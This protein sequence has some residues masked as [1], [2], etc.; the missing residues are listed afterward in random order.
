MTEVPLP[1]GMVTFLLTDVEGSTRIWESDGGG[2][3]SAF[4]RHDALVA[5]HLAA[6]GGARPRDQGEGDSAFAVF[7]R[8][9]AAVACALELQRA[10]Y[11]EAWPPDASIRV[12]MALHT[13]EAELA[14]GNY[15]G[16]AVH[17]CA[18]L[19]GLAHGGQILMSEATAQIVRDELSRGVTLRDMGV[20]ELRGLVRS[21]RVYQL[22]HPELPGDFPPLQSASGRPRDLPTGPQVPLPASLA[23]LGDDA[24]VGRRE[25]LAALEQEWATAGPLGAR[26][27]LVGGEAGIGKTRLAAH[28]AATA[29]AGGS[30]VLFGRCDE[31]ALRP[32]QPVAEALSSYLHA[33]PADSIQY[34]LGR[35]AAE[36]STLVPELGDRVPGVVGSGWSDAESMRF[37]MFEAVAL[38]LAEL[39][40]ATPVLVVIDDLHW[41]DKATLLMVRHLTRHA[42]LGRVL[43]LATHREEATSSLT[44]FADMLVELDREHA[45]TR[46]RLIG[47]DDADVTALLGSGAGERPEARAL[48]LAQTLRD[49]TEGNPFFLRETLRHLA[50]TGDIHQE[51]GQWVA[52]TR[53]DRLGVPSGVRGV[54]SQRLARFSDPANRV[55]AAAAVIGREFRLDVLDAVTDLDEDSL[56]ETLDEA[57]RAG[58]L[59]EVPAV[60]GAY[61]FSHALV[62]QTIYEGLTANRRVRLHHRVGDALEAVYSGRPDP[63]LAELAYHYSQAAGLGDDAKAIEYATRAGDR[64]TQQLAYEDAFRQYSMALRVLD[65]SP[66]DDDTR[67]F[68]LLCAIGDAA[69]RASEVL[70]ARA[71]YREAA[72]LARQL[73]DP[74]RLATAA[75]GFGGAGFRPWWSVDS[76]D[77]EESVIQLLEEALDAFEPGDSP[78]RV[79]LLGLLAHQLYL[80]G[81][82]ERRRLLTDESV[83]M[84]RRLGD[85]TTLVQALV[86]WRIARWQSS[87]AHERLAVSDE[88]LA[89][90]RALDQ[91]ELIMQALTFRLVDLMEL[92]DIVAAD[93]DAAELEGTALELH[94]PYYQWATVLYAAMRALLAGRFAEA[95]ALGAEGYVL[96]LRADPANAAGLA[97]AQLAILRREEGRVEELRAIIAEAH[98]VAPTSLVWRAAGVMASL[99]VGDLEE[100]R[101]EF[102]ACAV[103]DLGDVPDD[104]FRTITWVL[105]ADSSV[106]LGDADRAELLYALLLPSR[107][108]LV[109]LLNCVAFLGSVSYYLGALALTKG[110]L[111][112]AARHLEEAMACHLRLGAVPFHARTQLAYVRL[113]LARGAPGD[114]EQARPMLDAVIETAGR[115]GMRSLLEEATALR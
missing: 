59:R 31:E 39:S 40:A 46:I 71:S 1:S 67:R 19:R 95:E 32:Y 16:S 36:L 62:R 5:E 111:D 84:A 10:L 113:L 20:H 51:D 101:T 41:A 112:E 56:F 79:Q 78:T 74:T 14:N 48:A 96:G 102:E 72:Q 47:L 30:T 70:E 104:F 55:L 68:E 9:T 2:A 76:G 6:Y 86:Y 90:A 69:W 91:R 92:G 43:L 94:V 88:A 35:S 3:R 53:L 22:C 107:D 34:R 57:V 29:H 49:E 44:P 105:L 108:Q 45:V 26:L 50:E 85:R 4:E 83:A 60:V 77:V 17:R 64:A 12:R 93:A 8:A 52:T 58:L 24:F 18:R 109:V 89:L 81:E 87:N 13:G 7:P 110:S 80:S 97:G 75:L 115:L 28:F 65:A 11:A 106:R 61:T 100:A 63:P 42:D 99:A 66:G 73:G 33:L 54:V 23:N 103:G 15:K 37:R 98:R 27:V 82:V 25:E 21:E 114:A 38:L